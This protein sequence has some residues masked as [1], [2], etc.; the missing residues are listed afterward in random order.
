MASGLFIATLQFLLVQN[1][2]NLEVGTWL[3]DLAQ[4]SAIYVFPIIFVVSLL[5]S[6]LGTFLTPATN[7]EVLKS[8]YANV[9]PWGWW[10]PIYKTLKK[11]DETFEK[12]N[13]FKGDMLNCIIGIVWQ[14]SMILLPIYL[15][16][17][18]YPKTIVSLIVF[19]ITSIILKYTWLDKVKKIRN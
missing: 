7:M 19:L 12:N 15:V 1:K 6:F 2:A 14:S 4:L 8:F 3:Y 10:H 5:G 11:E 16:I 13:E 17:R 18:D 9:R